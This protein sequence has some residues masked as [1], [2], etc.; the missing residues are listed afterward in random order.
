MDTIK[1]WQSGWFYITEPRDSNWPVAAPKFLSGIP[2][3]LT[4][5][6]KK[7]LSRDS[8]VELTGLQTCIQNMTNKKIKLVNMVQV[9]L[10]C[11]ILPCQ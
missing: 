11:R 9:M 4:S 1:G 2:T 5:W 7:G 10:F 6:K 8:A 3:W